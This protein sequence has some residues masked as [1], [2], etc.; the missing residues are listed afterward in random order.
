MGDVDRVFGDRSRHGRGWFDT[1]GAKKRGDSREQRSSTVEGPHG[2]RLPKPRIDG[3]FS[4]V[5]IIAFEGL[6]CQLTRIKVEFDLRSVGLRG[7]A[8][9]PSLIEPS[10]FIGKRRAR[11][12]RS[13]AILLAQVSHWLTCRLLAK[14]LDARTGRDGASELGDGKVGAA[15]TGREEHPL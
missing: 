10:G 7:T 3:A 5:L 12:F 11:F 2:W 1:R 9:T 6:D 14:L 8:A 15:R 4:P 13:V